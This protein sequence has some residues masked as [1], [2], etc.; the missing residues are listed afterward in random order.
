[1][2]TRNL[3]G[4]WAWEFQQNYFCKEL[5]PAVVKPPTES[6]STERAPRVINEKFIER[7]FECMTE[8]DRLLHETVFTAASNRMREEEK[9]LKAIN[10]GRNVDIKSERE[11]IP[12]LIET[13]NNTP[14]RLLL[15]SF[16]LNSLENLGRLTSIENM[17][18]YLDLDQVSS[19]VL[20]I[21][22]FFF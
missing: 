9:H 17:Q 7:L 13:P 19:F 10:Y 5:V 14:T 3:I 12:D 6:T 21:F 22:F 15:S 2:M 18:D 4:R 1:M 20:L 8:D 11:K 16:G